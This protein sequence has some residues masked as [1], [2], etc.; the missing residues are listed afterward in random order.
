M[1]YLLLL[2]TLTTS[3]YAADDFNSIETGTLGCAE[4]FVLLGDIAVIGYGL[5]KEYTLIQK[6]FTTKE[7]IKLAKTDQEKAT[8]VLEHQFAKVALIA[9]TPI[10]ALLTGNTAYAASKLAPL[11]WRSLQKAFGQERST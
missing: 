7:A 3:L 1:T 8:A 5:Y 11:A 4:S 9:E 10:I 6:F 2:L